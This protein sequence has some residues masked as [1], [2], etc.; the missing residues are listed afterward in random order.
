MWPKNSW[1]ESISS[2]LQVCEKCGFSTV[3]K[4]KLRDHIRAKH[5]VEKHRKCPYCDYR[6]EQKQKIHFHIDI[7][8]P[9]SGQKNFFCDKCQMGFIYQQT[10]THHMKF[11]CKHSGKEPFIYYKKS[12]PSG[13]NLRIRDVC[14]PNLQVWSI[15]DGSDPKKSKNKMAIFILFKN[16]TTFYTNIFWYVQPLRSFFCRK[17]LT[18]SDGQTAPLK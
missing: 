5:E 15:L 6:S 3:S 7:K 10:C 4:H 1:T 17:T 12:S 2:P 18:H 11:K 16:V 14:S 9:E 8:H 13:L